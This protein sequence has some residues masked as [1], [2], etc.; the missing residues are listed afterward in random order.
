MSGF[1]PPVFLSRIAERG[2]VWR[3]PARPP[4]VP[5]WLVAAANWIFR[6]QIPPPAKLDAAGVAKML[7]LFWEGIGVLRD[8]TGTPE[9]REEQARRLYNRAVEFRQI[10]E[11]DLSHHR[12][13]AL[14]RGFADI[15][16][17]LLEFL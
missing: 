13:A 8:F 6:R 5:R 9:Q 14:L 10:I 4:R 12:R 15:E 7:K 16:R 1:F 2:R 11:A 3:V 17:R